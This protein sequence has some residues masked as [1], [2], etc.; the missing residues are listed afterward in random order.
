LKNVWQGKVEVYNV[1]EFAGDRDH[2]RLGRALDA[3]LPGT[4]IKCRTGYWSRGHFKRA[5][6]ERLLHNFA[7]RGLLDYA[8]LSNL[9]GPLL[10]SWTLPISG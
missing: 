5:P 3:L 1:I 7:R 10:L 4:R 2:N 6:D 8:G 9:D